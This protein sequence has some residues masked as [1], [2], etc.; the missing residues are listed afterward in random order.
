VLLLTHLPYTIAG[1]GIIGITYYSSGGYSYYYYGGNLTLINEKNGIIDATGANN[2]LQIYSSVTNS[3]LIEATGAAGLWLYAYV[4]NTGGIVAASA[5]SLVDLV[6]GQIIGGTLQGSGSFLVP[7]GHSETPSRDN[8]SIDLTDIQFA[9]AT[10][11]YANGIL[12]VKDGI[13]DIAHI[14][15]S[16]T[17]I[18]ASFTLQDD[19]QGGVL[20]TDPPVQSK[21]Q[22]SNVAL[23]GSYMASM[24]LSEGHGHGGMLINETPSI[25]PQTLLAHPH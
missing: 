1:A 4:N 22:M 9:T 15:F 17:H 24:F 12:T 23:L 14:K 20:I 21:T 8:Q 6:G 3:G 11:S 7:D 2:Q 16:G 10:K 5:N 25:A 18:L 19:G 13:G